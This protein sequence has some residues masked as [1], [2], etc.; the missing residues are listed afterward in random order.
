MS[1]S[2]KFASPLA[3]VVAASALSLAASSAMAAVVCNN[4]GFAIPQNA[5]GIYVNLVTGTT[6]TS[7]SAVE[8][9]DLNLYGSVRLQAYPGA[10]SSENNAL[11][12]TVVAGANN[13][14]YTVL[15][16]GEPIGPS[17][18]FTPESGAMTNFN[19]GVSGGYLGI[20]FDNENTGVANYGWLRLTTTAPNGY[21]ANVTAYCYDDTGA[22][23]NA[24]TTPVAL[25]NFSVD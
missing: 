14:L 13:D 11:V 16:A 25:Q 6:G 5:D 2:K 18:S 9:F 7:S 20:R 10:D 19:A 12:G 23:L 17:S 15:S 4:T 3:A 22:A 24:G 21:P 8:G 1:C